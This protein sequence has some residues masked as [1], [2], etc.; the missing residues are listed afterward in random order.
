MHHLYGG[1]GITCEF[2]S[3]KEFREWALEVFPNTDF[4]GLEF[5]RI[6]SDKHYTRDNIRLV[7]PSENQRNRR[8]NVK[9]IYKGTSISIYDFPSPY[10]RD[11]TAHY[12]KMGF[13]GEEIIELHKMSRAD[14]RRYL[15]HI[16]GT[17]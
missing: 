6:D 8:D 14:L 11:Q 17:P 1:R 9:V 5:D 3:A 4:K 13:T 15:T 12:A 2:Q 7:T 16:K 10:A